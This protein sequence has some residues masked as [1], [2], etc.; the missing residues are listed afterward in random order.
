[1]DIDVIIRGRL[2]HLLFLAFR[3][4]IKKAIGPFLEIKETSYLYYVSDMHFAHSEINKGHH[5]ARKPASSNIRALWLQVKAIVL[6]LT[7]SA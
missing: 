2:P 1:M 5:S 6:Q 3:V 4:L 7:L